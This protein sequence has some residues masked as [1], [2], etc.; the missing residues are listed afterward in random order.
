MPQR[1]DGFVRAFLD[2]IG[3]CGDSSGNTIHREE[4]DRFGFSTQSFCPMIPGLRIYAVL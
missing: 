3:H 2:R 4:Y 1:R